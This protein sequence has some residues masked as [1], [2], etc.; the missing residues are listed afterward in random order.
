MASCTA[1][2]TARRARSTSR[3]SGWGRTSTR[4]RERSARTRRAWRRSARFDT[5]LGPPFDARAIFSAARANDPLGR[6]VVDETA[7]RIAL[8]LVPIASVAD[9]SLVVLGGGLGSNGD[10]L[11]SPVRR[12]LEGW[13]PFA[14]RV[15]IS[16]LG[17]A[18]VLTGALAVGLS[19]ALENVFLNRV[20]LPVEVT[21]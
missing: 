20:R 5:E 21:P 12:F 3:S 6:A 10:L 9:V 11:L 17:E 14:P 7:R 15:E 13:I 2:I 4:A 1:A 16:S 19:T 8:H 18:A